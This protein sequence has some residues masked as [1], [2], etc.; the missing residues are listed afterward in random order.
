MW[1][2][3][4]LDFLFLFLF[5]KIAMLIRGMTWLL[6]YK[7]ISCFL[8]STSVF[9]LIS[10][11]NDFYI[12]LNKWMIYKSL[13]VFRKSDV[14]YFD[15]FRTRIRGHLFLANKIQYL[16]RKY[17]PTTQQHDTWKILLNH[18][19]LFITQ[20]NN[21]REIERFFRWYEYQFESFHPLKANKFTCFLLPWMFVSVYCL[22]YGWIATVFRIIKL[23]F[24]GYA[25][26]FGSFFMPSRLE[27]QCGTIASWFNLCTF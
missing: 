3:I 13:R 4:S 17:L 23:L 15:E 1:T 24:Y 16:Q 9:Y 5:D 6:I 19:F 10:S 22:P 21:L 2:N 8:K 11:Q 26:S 27:V 20:Q 7:K 12:F 25:V 18:S 14:K